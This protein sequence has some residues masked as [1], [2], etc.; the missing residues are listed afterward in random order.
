MPRCRKGGGLGAEA[1]QGTKVGERRA[2]ACPGNDV[3]MQTAC[4]KLSLAEA[5]P[6][7]DARECRAEACSDVDAWGARAE[8]D[9][10]G[11][12]GV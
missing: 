4:F 6:G 5:C 12:V 2:V 1:C 11:D 7:F 8:S 3:G 9:P 10:G